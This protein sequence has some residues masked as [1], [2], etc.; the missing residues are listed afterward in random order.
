MSDSLADRLAGLPGYRIERELGGGGMSRVFL[1]EEAALSRRVAIKVLESHGARVDADRFRREVLL[2]AQLSHPHI[3]PLLAAGEIDGLLYYIM[4]FV[5]GQSLRGRLREGELSIGEVIRLL[6]N[7]SAALSYAH[8]RGIVHRDIKPDNVIVTGG[9]AVVLDFGVSKAL[10]ASTQAPTDGITGA[11]LAIGTPRYMAPEQVVAD[12]DID[13]RADIYALGILAYE[14]L[15]GSTPFGGNDPVKI[16]RAHLSEMPEP[17]NNRRAGIPPTIAALVMRCLEKDRERRPA[18]A[19]EVLDLLDSMATPSLTSAMTL[20]TAASR[21]VAWATS[22]LM[23]ALVYL[24]AAGVMI[25]GLKWLAAQGQI[26]DRLMVFSIVLALLGLP[27]VVAL[28]LLLGLRRA[29]RGA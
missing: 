18:S 28:G 15:T 8:A 10:A 25:A 3:V 4:P 21:G 29:E 13:V 6:R 20:G 14:L 2:S 27:V 19:T 5:D 23:P 26:G 12:P 7:I 22:A 9:V 17:V 11:G 16:V 24:V 1:A